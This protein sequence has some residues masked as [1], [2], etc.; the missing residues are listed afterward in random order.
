MN[1]YQRGLKGIASTK[2]FTKY[3]GIDK[4]QVASFKF[5]EKEP[6]QVSG[7]KL[8]KRKPNYKLQT[9]EVNYD[10]SIR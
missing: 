1:E 6:D 7:D 2:L 9:K 8:E 4:F 10:H 3:G 5:R